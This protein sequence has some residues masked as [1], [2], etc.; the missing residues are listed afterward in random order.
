MVCRRDF[1]KGLAAGTAGVAGLGCGGGGAVSGPL[2]P[3]GAGARTVRVAL[4]PIGETVAVFEG[5][6]VLALTRVSATSVIAVSRICTHEGCT[7]LLP[8]APVRTLDCPC[9]GSRFTTAGAVVNGPALRPLP[10]FPARID[11]EQVVITLS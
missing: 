2:A 7:V 8:E 4:P 10:S 9:H 11:G 1:V 6:I 5:D 3:P